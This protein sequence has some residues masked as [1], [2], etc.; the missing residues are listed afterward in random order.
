MDASNPHESPKANA[1]LPDAGVP[2]TRKSG[3]LRKDKH[4]TASLL[5][6]VAV[7]R[8]L[9]AL[10]I[11]SI[12]G[13]EFQWLDWV[14][15]LD[16]LVFVALAIWARWA[17][18]TAAAIGFLLYAAYLGTQAAVS[19]QLLR[20]GWVF[21]LPTAVLLTI[22][23]VCGFVCQENEMPHPPEERE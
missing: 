21:K 2:V 3:R 17:P 1:P 18:G 10:F 4:P 11:W 8:F 13:P 5:F 19:L 9:T 14:F 6:G 22:A 23:L 15:C 12:R 7:I 16:F 20:S